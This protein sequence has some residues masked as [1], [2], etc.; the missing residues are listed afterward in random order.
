MTKSEFEKDFPGEVFMDED[1]I[2]TWPKEAN[3]FSNDLYTRLFILRRI[4]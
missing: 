1:D 2:T 4:H 3:T